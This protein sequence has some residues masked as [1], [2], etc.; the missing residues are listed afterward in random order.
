MGKYS[1]LCAYL[2][3]RKKHLIELTFDEIESILGLKLP[4]S[5]QNSRSWWANDVTHVQARDGWLKAGYRTEA[6]NLQDNNLRF[7]KESSIDSQ[8]LSQK[9]AIN[10]FTPN[11]FS[12]FAQVNMSAYYNKE[13]TSRKKEEWPKYFDLVSSDFQIVGDS[14]FIS[15][16]KK[17]YIQ[18]SKLSAI[19]EQVW[20]LEKIGAKIKFL[21]FAEEQVPRGWLNKYGMYNDQVQFFVLN[22][23]IPIPLNLD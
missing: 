8:I 13:L 6:V 4:A 7:R 18:S 16:G 23:N 10:E 21:V 1:K 20:L 5:A 19:T 17:T 2:E 3:K 22:S 9:K 11:T 14:K 15:P 12:L